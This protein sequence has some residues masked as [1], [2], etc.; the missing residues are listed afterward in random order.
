VASGRDGASRHLVAFLD[1]LPPGARILELGCGGGHDA[2]AMLARGF[3]VD[4]TDGVAEIARQAEARIGCAVRV[5][6]FDQLD[7]VEDYDAIWCHASLLHVPLRALPP[8]L[9][10]IHRA[11]RPGGWHF[12]SYKSGGEEGRDRFGRYFNY[13]SPA[14]LIELY[15]EAASWQRIATSEYEGGGYDGRQGPWIT[16]TTQK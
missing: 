8:V 15:G 2:A 3:A 6:R 5:M 7:A 1:L 9:S 16:V 10:R 12:A 14:R 4:A 11:L 13:P